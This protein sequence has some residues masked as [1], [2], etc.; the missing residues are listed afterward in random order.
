M[1]TKMSILSAFGCNYINLVWH[2]LAFVLI[3][4]LI[5]FVMRFFVLIIGNRDAVSLPN[6]HCQN[7]GFQA[8]GKKQASQF[9]RSFMTLRDGP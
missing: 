6:P 8:P 7:K 9:K 1:L 3:V 2:N 5:L 4:Q